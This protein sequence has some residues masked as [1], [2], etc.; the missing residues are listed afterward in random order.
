MVQPGIKYN[1]NGFLTTN[2]II[3]LKPIGRF[4]ILYRAEQPFILMLWKI[5]EK[6]GRR[7]NNGY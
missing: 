1:N 7:R 6:R 4:I 3:Y 5:K 2:R